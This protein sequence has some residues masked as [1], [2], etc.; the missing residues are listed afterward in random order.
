MEIYSLQGQSLL[1]YSNSHNEPTF[2]PIVG[3]FA[4]K[5]ARNRAG[6]KAA[7]KAG[8]FRMSNNRWTAGFCPN[9]VNVITLG[10]ARNVEEAG[11]AR[12]SA[13]FH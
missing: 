3:E 11:S 6:D 13:I 1:R 8:K 10:P 9:Q 12:Q 2:L 5:L 7:A 4:A